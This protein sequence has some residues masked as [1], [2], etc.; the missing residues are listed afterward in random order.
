MKYQM[1]YPLVFVLEVEAEN[2]M[3]ARMLLVDGEPKD[4][5]IG[6]ISAPAD[7]YIWE[8]SMTCRKDTAHD[9]T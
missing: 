3:E 5:I 4:Y 9:Q 7:S 1:H 6:T 2:E 8:S